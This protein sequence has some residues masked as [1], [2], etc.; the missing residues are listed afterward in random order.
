MSSR[1][2]AH[3]VA[4]RWTR[5]WVRNLAAGATVACESAPPSRAI[6]AL[7]SMLVSVAGLAAPTAA[8]VRAEIDA[9][10]VRLETSGCRF[11]RNDEWHA[12]AAA[13]A[14]LLR[15]LE[16][17]E[18]YGTITTTEQF[19]DAAATKSSVSGT[20]Y[21][22]QCGSAA[23]VPSSAWLVAQLKQLRATPA[24]GLRAARRGSPSS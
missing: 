16:Y 2:A 18:K 17:I 24:K 5:P 7:A 6:V 13:K 12:G 23:S 15:K 8:P 3:A 19:I 11:G 22:V 20:R 10:L 4:V 14:H 9:L 1:I 21:V